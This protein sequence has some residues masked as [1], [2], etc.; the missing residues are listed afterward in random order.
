MVTKTHYYDTNI[1]LLMTK[2][3][4]NSVR[5]TQLSAEKFNSSI[6]HSKTEDNQSLS[7]DSIGANQVKFQ[8]I[9]DKVMHSTFS[10]ASR[11]NLIMSSG[12]SHNWPQSSKNRNAIA[13][14]LDPK[15]KSIMK[16]IL[17]QSYQKMKP[18]KETSPSRKPLSKT[19]SKNSWGSQNANEIQMRSTFNKESHDKLPEARD[20]MPQDSITKKK[21]LK[22]CSSQGQRFRHP[23]NVVIASHE[24]VDSLFDLA[25]KEYSNHKRQIDKKQFLLFQTD[26]RRIQQQKKTMKHV[27]SSILKHSSDLA[28]K[29][30]SITEFIKN[31][32]QNNTGT[33][34]SHVNFSSDHDNETQYRQT[35]S[36]LKDKEFTPMVNMDRINAHMNM[37]TQRSI[38]STKEHSMQMGM[39]KTQT[40][41]F[42]MTM[43]SLR[44]TDQTKIFNQERLLEIIVK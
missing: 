38:T 9:R 32:K 19:S 24:Q 40:A 8:D 17:N 30:G 5:N 1:N 39:N 18:S 31:Q 29:N 37:K 20:S 11:E 3:Q 34:M 21:S 14:S 44:N 23:S 10:N 26:K 41:P 36:K 13:S 25:E 12:I 15:I 35:M 4:Q 33:S 27:K 6:Q 2:D 28:R 7:K 43:K 22:M 42:R 16:P